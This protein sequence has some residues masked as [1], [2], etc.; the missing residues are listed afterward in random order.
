M[1]DLNTCPACGAQPVRV[2][3]PF[4]F[5]QY[6]YE[7]LNRECRNWSARYAESMACRHEPATAPTLPPP[8]PGPEV[9]Y[10]GDPGDILGHGTDPTPARPVFLWTTRHNDFGDV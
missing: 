3:P 9:F 4:M 2:T 5:G 1:E 7:C 6:Y 10:H 8:G